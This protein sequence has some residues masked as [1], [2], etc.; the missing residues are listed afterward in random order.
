MGKRRMCTLGLA[1]LVLMAGMTLDAAAAERKLS[2]GET[3]TLTEDLVLTGADVLEV[4]GTAERPCTILGNGHQVKTQ[5]EWTGKLKLAWCTIKGLGR[6]AP[7]RNGRTAG[8]IHAF[9]LTASGNAEVVIEH[10]TFD[11]SSSVNIVNNGNSTAVFR[12]N[13]VLENSLTRA[14]KA[15]ELCAGFFF[16]GG[17][18]PA[19]KYFQANRI[20]KTGAYLENVSNWLIGG[21]TDVEGNIL[22][23]QRACISAHG[24]GLVIKRNYLH[25]LLPVDKV[26]W[27]WSQVT[28]MSPWGDTSENVIRSGHWVVQNVRG[29]FHNN[30]VTEVQG[31]DWLRIGQAKVHH[32]IFAHIELSPGRF[33]DTHPYGG[34]SGIFC[35][36]PTDGLQ[37]FNNVLD[38]DGGIGRAID[39][40]EG[41]S[42][43]SLRNNVFRRFSRGVGP[44]W[45]QA[46]AV[47]PLP[48][49][50]GYSDYNC[51]FN[52]G[53]KCNNYSFAVKGKK[54]RVDDGFARHDLHPGGP[55][56]EQVDPKIKGP[57]PDKFPFSDEDVKSGKV[58]V[59]QILKF[60]RDAYTPADGSPLVDGGDPADGDGTDIGAVDAGKPAPVRGF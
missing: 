35:C 6:E 34:S 9:D 25:V 36:Y 29:D 30:L 55:V 14:D 54:E 16:A 52:P 43:P 53:G 59:S 44:N 2:A 24:E 12:N 15:A 50:L 41:A 42:F 56:D 18:S 4:N 17:N 46:E 58:T 27:Y 39:A 57:L 21:D 33:G 5:G 19:R 1:A 20:Y 48:E 8:Y 23:G 51:F 32:N 28:T 37:V 26:N 31:H 7:I 40:E 13:T 22:I 10:C 45:R 47:E 11:A 49:R 38:G 3:L 60:Y